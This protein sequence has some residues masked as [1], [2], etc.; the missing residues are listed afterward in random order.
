MCKRLRWPW[1]K[2]QR[3]PSA[4]SSRGQSTKIPCF[5]TKRLM[6]SPKRWPAW[7]IASVPPKIISRIDIK[8]SQPVMQRRSGAYGMLLRICQ[9]GWPRV[10]ASLQISQNQKRRPD[11]SA[12]RCGPSCDIFVLS[13]N[14]KTNLPLLFQIVKFSP[15]NMRKLFGG[16]LNCPIKSPLL[17]FKKQCSVN[18]YRFAIVFVIISKFSL[19]MT[20]NCQR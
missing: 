8:V 9:G 19:S 12:N 6:R 18:N 11:Q 14:R 13:L 17:S 15:H 4:P 10:K 5:R 20:K 3:S 7:K 16:Y 1:S 2:Q